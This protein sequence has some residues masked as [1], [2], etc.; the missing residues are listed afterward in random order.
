MYLLF[1]ILGI[2]SLSAGVATLSLSAPEWYTPLWS[3]TMIVA[4]MVCMFA[5]LQPKWECFERWPAVVV[6]GLMASYWFAAYIL[7]LSGDQTRGAGS[8]LLFVAMM[9][10]VSRTGHLFGVGQWFMKIVKR[11][12]K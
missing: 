2:T 11:F 7:Y 9:L 3:W 8:V 10:V 5:S 6:S 12:K 4:A 1:M